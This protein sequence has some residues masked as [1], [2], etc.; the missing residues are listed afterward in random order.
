MARVELRVPLALL[1]AVHQLAAAT[2]IGG[3]AHLTLWA[4]RGR[5]V[6]MQPGPD[7]VLRRF[8]ALALAAVG[9][10][11]DA[12]LRVT[13]APGPQGE[14]GLAARWMESAGYAFLRRKDL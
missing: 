2:W 11:A 12:E 10:W 1:D 3:L 9:Q 5:R 13:L 4:A 6:A 7:V 8:S 14:A